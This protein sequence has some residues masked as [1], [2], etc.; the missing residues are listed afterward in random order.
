MGGPIVVRYAMFVLGLFIGAFGCVLMIKAN[1]GVSPWDVFH[2]GLQKTFGLTIGL[3]SQ[4]VGVIVIFLSFVLAKIKPTFGMFLN[5]IC[6]GLFLDMFLWM[7]I[8]PEVEGIV[9]RVLMLLTGLLV[10]AVGIGM[11]LSPR[12]GAGPRD[13]FMLAMNERMGW[14]IQR[15]RLII[16]VS[17]LLAGAALGGP[18]S[19]GTVLVAVLTGPLIQRTIPFWQQVM[20]KPY[21][22]AE[23]LHRKAS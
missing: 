17:V 19:V 22:M 20:Q 9:Q 12:L 7:N 10:S 23:P 21:G 1:L 11:Y 3:W 6:F 2:I 13:S 15:V 4:I 18:V 16:E 8:I 5:M 14:S